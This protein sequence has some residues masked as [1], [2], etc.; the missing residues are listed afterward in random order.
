MLFFHDKISKLRI[1]WNERPLTEDDFYRICRRLGV[2]IQEMPLRVSGFYYSLKGGHYIAID[3][4]LEPVQKRFVMFHELAHF[5]LHAPDKGVTANFHGIGKKTRKEIEADAV[6]LCAL[7]PKTWIETRTVDDIAEH[8]GL[9]HELLA[10]RLAIY[11]R[12]RI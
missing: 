9:S 3:S 11:E 5:L 2:V 8:E 1:K 4:R 6:A 12:H 10:Q 7:I